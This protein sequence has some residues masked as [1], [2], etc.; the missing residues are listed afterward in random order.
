MKTKPQLAGVIVPDA[1][2]PQ[3]IPLHARQNVL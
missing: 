1:T 3:L 2:P